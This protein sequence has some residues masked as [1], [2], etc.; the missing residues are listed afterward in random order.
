MSNPEQ[1]M[2]DEGSEGGEGGE[3]GEGDQNRRAVAK[4]EQASLGILFVAA[5]LALGSILMVVALLAYAAMSR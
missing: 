4:P 2:S 1:R 3:G 5:A